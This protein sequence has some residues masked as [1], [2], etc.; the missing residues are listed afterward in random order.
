MPGREGKGRAMLFTDD[1]K[2]NTVQA[3]DQ[4]APE[5]TG[6]AQVLR[7]FVSFILKAAYFRCCTHGLDQMVASINVS[8]GVM[9]Y[10]TNVHADV[11]IMQHKQAGAIP[12]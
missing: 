3:S 4:C 5:I 11:S 12:G 8:M 1:S 10:C 6:F 7:N 9:S 2:T